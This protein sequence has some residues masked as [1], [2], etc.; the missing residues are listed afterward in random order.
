MT[1]LDL[2]GAD[3]QPAAR[4][5]VALSKALRG[6]GL[7]L[8][9][10]VLGLLAWRPHPILGALTGM[11]LAGNAHALVT[12]DKTWKQA[13][14]RVGCHAVAVAGSLAVPAYPALA[15]VGASIAANLLIDSEG[16]AEEWKRIRE[17]REVID[18]TPDHETKALVK[19]K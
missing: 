12:K 11:V 3:T 14:K 13:A 5:P 10:G 6:V 8:G 9:G 19:T 1:G 18:V 4:P 17:E 15:Y 7:T 2:L 16:L